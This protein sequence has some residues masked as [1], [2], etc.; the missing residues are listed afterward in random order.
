MSQVKRPILMLTPSTCS[1]F[2]FLF[3]D[4]DPGPEFQD[5]ACDFIPATPRDVVLYMNVGDMLQRISNG[6]WYAFLM[7][8]SVISEIF[9][10]AYL[11]HVLSAPPLE[12]IVPRNF[13]TL[14]YCAPSNTSPFLLLLLDIYPS[15]MHRVRVSGKDSGQTTP[16]RY[17]IP[18]FVCPTPDG[19]IEPLPSLVAAAGKKN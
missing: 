12:T 13:D 6:T 8:I 19:I 5:R 17:S 9:I 3:Q 1:S 15:G 14:L 2:T 18:Y 7:Y 11:S 16:P 10:F 4:D